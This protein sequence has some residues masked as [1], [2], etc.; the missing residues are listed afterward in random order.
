MCQRGTMGTVAESSE[1]V[2]ALV[3][4]GLVDKAED[5]FNSLH[6]WRDEDGLY[7]TGYVY[8][9]K[10]FWPIEKPTWTAGAVLLAADTFMGSRPDMS[11]SFKIGPH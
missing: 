4:I 10:K 11:F 7:W 3:K 5:L 9:D 2:M 1:L 8:T 6:Q